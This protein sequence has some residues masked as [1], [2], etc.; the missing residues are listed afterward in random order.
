[1]DIRWLFLLAVLFVVVEVILYRQLALRHLQYSRTLSAPSIHAGSE[2]QMVEIIANRKFLPLPWIVLEATFDVSWLF[3]NQADLTI[4]TNDKSQYHRSYFTLRPFTR[5]TRRHTIHC[6]RRGVFELKSASMLCGDFLGLSTS[7]KQWALTGENTKLV[8]FPPLIPQDSVQLPSHSWQGD[9]AV[10]RW[11]LPDPFIRVGSRPYQAG[12]PLNQI[13]W[14]ATARATTLQVHQQAFTADY[15]L[16]ILLNFVV[17]SDM[18]LQSVTEPER[19][20]A[21]ISLAATLATD[22]IEQGIAVGFACNGAVREGKQ[23]IDTEPDVGQS[24]LHALLTDMAN[25]EIRVTKTFEA[26]LQNEIDT[27]PTGTDYLIIS[28][29]TDDTLDMLMDQLRDLGNAVEVLQLPTTA[30]A[31]AWLQPVTPQKEVAANAR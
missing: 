20:E 26:L 30:E 18:W 5:I 8:V 14:K 25:L 6:H 13:N 2:I 7:R 29:Y 23:E 1:M 21:G 11:I 3:G 15:H 16:K 24:H 22:A 27:Y 31:N 4:Q 19:V 9:V 10:R 12:D 28:G 17:S